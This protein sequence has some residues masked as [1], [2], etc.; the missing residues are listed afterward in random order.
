MYDLPSLTHLQKVVVDE[1]SIKGEAQPYLVFEN[2][3]MRRAAS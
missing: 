2:S 3:E 1:A